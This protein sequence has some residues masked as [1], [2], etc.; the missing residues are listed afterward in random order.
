[1]IFSLLALVAAQRSFFAPV[2]Y[3]APAYS[4]AVSY[5]A[6]YVAPAPAFPSV[7]VATVSTAP[8]SSKA[9]PLLAGA[10]FGATVAVLAAKGRSGAAAKGAKKPAAKKPAAKT[11]AKPAA[12]KPAPKASPAARKP[13]RRAAPLRRNIGKSPVGKGGIFP[14]ITNKPGTYAK[15]LMLSSIDFLADEGDDLVG[16]GFMP[17]SVKQLYNPKGRKGLFAGCTTPAR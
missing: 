6:P 4:P 7:P 8:P 14:W 10:L 3:Q 17:D 11:A 1:M 9:V 12:A 2:G 13:V 15:P 16:W 5:A